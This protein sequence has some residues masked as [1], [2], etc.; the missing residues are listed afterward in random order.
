MNL[1]VKVIKDYKN[2]SK[3]WQTSE[4]ELLPQVGSNYRD[5]FRTLQNI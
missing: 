5:K 2:D 3:P 1:F 4:M